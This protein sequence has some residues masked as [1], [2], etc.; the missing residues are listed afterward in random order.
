VTVKTVTTEPDPDPQP[1]A[2]NGVTLNQSALELQP[3]EIV[4]LVATVSPANADNKAVIWSS[5]NTSVVE[6]TVNG[7]VI[8]FATGT[9]TITATTVDGDHKAS[10]VVTVVTNST[11]IDEL[12]SKDAKAWYA[13]DG[14]HLVNLEGY[15]CTAV[16]LSGQ[17]VRTFKVTSP[18]YR[19]PLNLPSGIYILTAQKPDNRKT[20][21]FI[22]L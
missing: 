16:S 19:Q 13:A 22:I 18:D 5:S 15:T 17:T 10:C 14:L 20:F 4:S 1:N 11:G 12:S 2:V 3:N 8:A 21:K 6:V 9:A 7:T